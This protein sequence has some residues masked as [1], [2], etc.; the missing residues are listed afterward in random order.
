MGRSSKT[1][2]AQEA[3]TL[4]LDDPTKGLTASYTKAFLVEE[5]ELDEDKDKDIPYVNRGNQE[6][7]YYQ[8]EK[9]VP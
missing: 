7:L 4:L 8:S 9:V 5:L 6:L 1:S 3:S 2:S